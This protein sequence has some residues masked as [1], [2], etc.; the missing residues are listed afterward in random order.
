MLRCTTRRGNRTRGDYSARSARWNPAF[1][2]FYLITS[3]V[4]ALCPGMSNGFIGWQLPVGVL[5]RILEGAS[6][7]ACSNEAGGKRGHRVRVGRVGTTHG[8]QPANCAA[9]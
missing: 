5:I 9:P 3:P 1:F 6:G 7:R 4:V 8:P 2:I